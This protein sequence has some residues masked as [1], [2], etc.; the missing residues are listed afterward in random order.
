MLLDLPVLDAIRGQPE[1][2]QAHAQGR[3]E[4]SFGAILAQSG[5]RVQNTTFYDSAG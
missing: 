1:K 2:R 3:L 4:P 5:L